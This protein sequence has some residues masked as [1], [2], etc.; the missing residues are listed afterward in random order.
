MQIKISKTPPGRRTRKKN[1]KCNC[2]A[3]CITHKGKKLLIFLLC[4]K[5]KLKTKI[6]G[7]A[8]CHKS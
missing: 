8:Y 2:K 6:P 3:F 4:G 5:L 1:Y 7:K